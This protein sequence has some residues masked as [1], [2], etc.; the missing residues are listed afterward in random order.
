MY[1]MPFA[2]WGNDFWKRAACGFVCT[3]GMFGGAI[4]FFYPMTILYR[5]SCI[6]FAGFHT[7]FYHGVMLFTCLTMLISGYHRYQADKWWQPFVACIFP[8]I[9]SIPANIVNYTVGADYMFFRGNSA[10]L[11][12]LLGGVSDPLTTV[13]I[14]ALYIAVPVSFYLPS[15]IKNLCKKKA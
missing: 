2:I 11:P 6:S 3:V 4:N 12:A 1:A 8:L 7:F 15:L 14:Y 13:I 5:Y 10:F 9:V